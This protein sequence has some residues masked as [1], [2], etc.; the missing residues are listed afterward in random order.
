MTRFTHGLVLGKF[1]PLHVGHEHLIAAAASACARVTV[2][3]LASAR[4]SIPLEVRAG[5]IRERFPMVEVVTGMDEAEVDFASPHAWDEHMRVIEALLPASV[6]AVFTSDP[7]GAELARRL[8]AAWQ[9]V[10]PGRQS[11]AISG[12]AVRADVA[13]SWW[14]LSPPVRE[15]FCRRVVVLGAESTGTT[16]LARALAERLGTIWVPEYGRTWT[17]QRPGGPEAPWHTAEFDLVAFE[18][19]R[20]ERDAM[21]TAP[22]PVIVSDTDVLATTIWHERYLGH[23]SPSV[24]RMAADGKPDLYVR[25]G[26]EIP[27]VQDG[28]RDGEH[29]RHAMQQRFR[30]V[31]AEQDVPWLEVRGPAAVRLADTVAR[32][33]RLLRRGWDL[34][35]PLG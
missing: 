1:Y 20:Q 27:L 6:D 9:Q 2:Q 11:L 14:A 26:D 22:I 17:V 32:V 16:T 21:R 29:L 12:T 8:G 34:A 15:W 4:E 35:P 24:V 13:G 30:D 3:V 7:Y 5:W 33:E 18:H 23:A 10:D 31:L 25:T 28:L 19:R